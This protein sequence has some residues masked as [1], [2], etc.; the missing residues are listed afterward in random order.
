MASVDETTTEAMVVVHADANADQL[1]E[2]TPAYEVFYNGKAITADISPYVLSIDV[3]DALGEADELNIELEDVD[4]RWRNAWY[5]DKGA[6][7]E[8]SLGYLGDPLVPQGSFQIDTIRL[9]GPPATVQI[10]ALTASVTEAI[11]TRV[12]R[13]FED[14]T[15]PALAKRLATLNGWR[16]MGEIEPLPIDHLTQF[17]ETDLAFLRRVALNYGYA[18][19]VLSSTKTLV[20]WHIEALCVQTPVRTYAEEDLTHYDIEDTLADAPAK[21]RNQR[22]HRASGTL[23]AYTVGENDTVVV[24]GKGSADA[25]NRNTLALNRATSAPATAQATSRAAMVQ[26]QLDRTTGTVAVWGDGT[27]AA[28]QSITLTGLGC[29]SGHY[30][31]QR[32]QHALRREGGFASNL[33]VKRVI[34]TAGNRTQA[35]KAPP[36]LDVYGI[37]HDGQIDVVG[38]SDKPKRKRA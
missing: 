24:A 31:L 33:E 17:G 14:T 3:T 20:L 23:V 10:R 1:A 36:K 2:P 18:L 8:V 5:P 6:T 25:S 28:G 34:A 22:H 37:G 35:G 9:S 15:L 30:T 21:V 38:Q 7:L 16:L 32:V 26:R 12:P 27:L 29:L 11:R 4:G 19:K 13:T